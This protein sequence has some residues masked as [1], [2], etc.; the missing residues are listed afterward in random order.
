MGFFSK[1]AP[2]EEQPAVEPAPPMH[3]KSLGEPTEKSSEEDLISKDLQ[4]GVAK[5]E[6]ITSVWSKRDLILAYTL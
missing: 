2:V 6:A 1:K 4:A 5:V 3:E